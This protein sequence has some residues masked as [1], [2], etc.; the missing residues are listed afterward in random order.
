MTLLDASPIID[1]LR[2]KDPVLLAEMK[3]VEGTICGITRSEILSGARNPADRAKLLSFLDGLNQVEIPQP[4]W[5]EIGDIQ[6]QLRAAGVTIPLTD[7]IL[8]TLSLALSIEVW[9]RDAHYKAARGVFP[10]LK[11]YSEVK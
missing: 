9:A 2:S 8:I 10:A 3:R 1:Y 5:D 4:M 6:S 7:T 11:L